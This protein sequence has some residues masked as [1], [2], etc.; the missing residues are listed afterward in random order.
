MLLLY[1]DLNIE[2]EICAFNL[3][4]LQSLGKQKESIGWEGEERFQRR[5]DNRAEKT[6]RKKIISNELN[7][8]EV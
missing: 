8:L 4:F 5:R 2:F 7:S 3:D 6:P 1:M